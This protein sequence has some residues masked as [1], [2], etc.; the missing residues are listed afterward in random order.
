ML[1]A[2]KRILGFGDAF[3][4]GATSPKEV[5][6][7]VTTGGLVDAQPIDNT[8]SHFVISPPAAPT[9]P[10]Q[11]HRMPERNTRAAMEDLCDTLP[12]R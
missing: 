10:H 7:G 4:A 2:S 11:R 6:A 8:T 5:G 9:N 12:H 1:T 3:C